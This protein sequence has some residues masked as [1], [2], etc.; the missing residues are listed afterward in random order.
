MAERHQ[1]LPPYL[2]ASQLQR[3]Q[4]SAMMIR[5]LRRKN[6]I[7]IASYI[8]TFLVLVVAIILIIVFV[9]LPITTPK[10]RVHSMTF[11][12]LEVGT[13]SN[14][15]FNMRFDVQ[16]RIKNKNFGKFEYDY[17]SVDYYYRGTRLTS[18]FIARGDVRARSTEKIDVS[19]VNMDSS[20]LGTAANSSLST[21]IGN[22]ILPLTALSKLDG[23]VEVMNIKKHK[24]PV[25]NCTMEVVISTKSLQN[26][27][28]L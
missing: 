26:L 13:T 28:C 2:P 15:S 25:M 27:N 5:D 22:G 3:D 19:F 1:Q 24:S 20:T 11:D 14:A 18:V 16:F 7:R 9:I 10:F 6:N 8:L 12:T 21:D 17:S 23:E 4:E